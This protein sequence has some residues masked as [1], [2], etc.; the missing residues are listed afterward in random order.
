[1]PAAR[2]VVI[3]GMGCV[4]ALGR[5]VPRLWD[6]CL[7][8]T[9]GVK[10][11]ALA[12]SPRQR[13]HAA[14]HDPEFDASDLVSPDLARQI[15]RFS[16]LALVA[17]HE[18][19]GQAGLSHEPALGERTA[20][21]IGSGIGGAASV[22]SGAYGFYVSQ[23]RP[24]PLSVA[25]MM[26]NAAASHVSMRFGAT[27]PC[28]CVASA[29][30][31]AAQAIG[32]GL[33]LIRSGAVDIA[34]VGGS[35][36]LLTPA[37]FHAWEA[38][39]VMTP[40]LC[41]PFAAD[42]NGMVLGEGA[43]ILVL[44]SAASAQRRK[45]PALAT[46]AGY[47]TSSDAGD[48]LRPD[49]LGGARAMRLALADAGLQ[50]HDIQHVNAH[51]TGTIAN[52]FAEGQALAAV[53]GEDLPAIPV[54]STKPVHGHALGA[55]GALELIVAIMSLADQTV[56]PT[57]NHTMTDARI[58][59]DIVTARRPAPLKAVM[60]NSLAFGGINASLIVSLAH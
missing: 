57:L 20:V 18:A 25:K 56:V 38:L 23:A 50:P 15:D 24:D 16:A 17:A 36:A 60:S 10:P 27:G 4:T 29:C 14:A 55:G 31:S 49:P 40:T 21:I 32:L 48:L 2:D 7:S 52:D 47:G 12:H 35:E 51:G 30:A 46:L 33:Q 34:I 43:G 54:T 3:T 44:E 6:A 9:S 53:F 58:P 26:P 22:D 8:G 39:R 13:I 37:G 5:G 45:A 41:R 28:F 59:L 11:I 42:R 1:V 19:I